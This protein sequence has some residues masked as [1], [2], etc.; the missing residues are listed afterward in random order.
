MPFTE[1]QVYHGSSWR[2]PSID[3]KPVGINSPRIDLAPIVR[4]YEPQARSGYGFPVQVD[5]ELWAE[6]GRPL[7]NSTGLAYWYTTIDMGTNAYVQRYVVLWN[8]TTQ[9]WTS[10]QGYLWRPVW[11]AGQAGL[12]VLDFKVRITNLVA[13]SP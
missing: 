8:P 11:G 10:Y 1:F 13:A 12:K 2:I 9:T 6:V 7:I 4:Y 5:A 3:A